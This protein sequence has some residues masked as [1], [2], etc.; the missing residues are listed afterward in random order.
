MTEIILLTGQLGSGKTTTLKHMLQEYDD[1]DVAAI[2]NEFAALGVDGEMLDKEGRKI[3]E[4]NNGCVC[5]SKSDDMVKLVKLLQKK[6]D[7]KQIFIETTG[8][9]SIKPV[10]EALA[11]TN[12]PIT[13][14]VTIMDAKQFSRSKKEFGVVSNQQIKYSSTIIINKEDQVEKNVIKKMKQE[15]KAINNE[16]QIIVTSH[17]KVHVKQLKTAKKYKP[18]K[19]EKGI[20]QKL[21]PELYQDEATK[22]I[23]KHAKNSVVI[24]LNG[25][26]DKH[27]FKSYL[28]NLPK[29][30]PRAKGYV[31][32]NDATY[33]FN[34]SNNAYTFEKKENNK[35][36]AIVLIGNIGFKEKIKQ[37]Y[38]INQTLRKPKKLVNW[39]NVT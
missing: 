3:A 24:Q 23:N 2:I 38:K 28:E 12:L 6:Y 32:T 1:N 26:V 21:F 34:Y 31:K 33:E 8:V 4:L 39:L 17:G 22:H 10:L 15:I 35:K 11:K 29:T 36:T 18:S 25:F 27:K 7:A 30:I 37:R 13:K 20:I 19:K 16:T 5:C 9:A 14:I